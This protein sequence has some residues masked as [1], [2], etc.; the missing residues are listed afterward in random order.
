MADSDAAGLEDCSEVV[1]SLLQALS[2]SAPARKA[3]VNANGVRDI[4]I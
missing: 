2:A 3:A 1:V 4:L